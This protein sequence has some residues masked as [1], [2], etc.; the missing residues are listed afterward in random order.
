MFASRNIYDIWYTS[1][2]HKSYKYIYRYRDHI[3]NSSF[4]VAKTQPFLII[5]VSSLKQKQCIQ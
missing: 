1:Y 3:H 2:Y 5:P 4:Y